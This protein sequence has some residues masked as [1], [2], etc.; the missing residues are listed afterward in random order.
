MKRHSLNG[1]SMGFPKISPLLS[2][3]SSPGSPWSPP[4]A[5]LVGHVATAVRVQALSQMS[6]DPLGDGHP[7]LRTENS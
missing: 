2:M 5:G 1:K 3:T 6:Q 7:F 4:V